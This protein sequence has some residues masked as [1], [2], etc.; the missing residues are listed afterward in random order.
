MQPPTR[1]LGA[2]EL[3][4]KGRALLYQRGL[5]ILKAIDC[6]T[7]AVDARP[8]IRAGLGRSGRRIHHV[9]LLGL[10]DRVGRDAARTRRGAAGARLG[11]GL[12]EAHC[13]L[14]CATILFERDD[15]LAGAGVPARAGAQPQIP[16]GDGLV[17]AVLS[18]LDRR[19]HPR[20][21]RCDHAARGARWPFRV[22]AFSSLVLEI[23]ER[24]VTTPWATPAW[25]R[26][27]SELVPGPLGPD[28]VAA[29][30]RAVTKSRASWPTARSQCPAAIHGRSQNL[31]S[32]L[33][34]LGKTEE[35]RAV[36]RRDER[37][38][39]RAST[40][41]RRCSRPRQPQS[42][43]WTRRLRSRSGRWMS[44]TRCS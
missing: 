43:T 10:Q 32:D 24:Y 38:A 7:E 9:G 11:P 22:R 36:Y 4:L 23:H 12:S 35:A 39:A 20:G 30:E 34:D 16:A 31:V 28:A 17:R 18:A 41:S 3:Y 5:S 14:A 19:T 8:D 27:R 40:C 29:L 13:A 26:A 1:N 6:F 21:T 15:A 42:E 44:G 37:Y 25:N 33:R 2:Y